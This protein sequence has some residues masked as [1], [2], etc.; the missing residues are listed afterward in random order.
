[1]PDLVKNARAFPEELRDDLL[2]LH[3]YVGSILWEDYGTF[4]SDMVGLMR[5]NHVFPAS[6]VDEFISAHDDLNYEFDFDPKG[7]PVSQ[8]TDAGSSGAKCHDCA[9]E[10]D[11]GVNFCPECGS[12]QNTAAFCAECGSKRDKGAKFCSDCGT[13]YQ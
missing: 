13:S 6:Y 4:A 12:R 5:A 10:V 1:V 11:P 9:T 7:P 8:G 3:S 2:D